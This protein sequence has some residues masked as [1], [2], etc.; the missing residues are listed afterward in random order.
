VE[1]GQFCRGELRNFVSW[2]GIWQ[3]LP[4]KTGF[5]LLLSLLSYTHTL[6]EGRGV[7]VEAVVVWTRV[8]QTHTLNRGKNPT[9]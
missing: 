2:S 9:C 6:G 5:C 8:R 1:F 7:I 3:N 4:R